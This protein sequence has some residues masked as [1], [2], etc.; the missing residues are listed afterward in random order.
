MSGVV[1][2]ELERTIRDAYAAFAEGDIESLR[3]FFHE[4]VIYVNPPYAMEAGTR[5]GRD[6]VEEIWNGI[7]SLFEFETVEVLEIARLRAACSSSCVIAGEA[8]Q[9]ARPWTCRWRTYSSIRDGRVARLAWYGT[10]DE[11]AEAAGL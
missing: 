2:A 3:E 1:D 7:Y 11:A 8:R 10:R 5:E 6:A 4:D 9:A